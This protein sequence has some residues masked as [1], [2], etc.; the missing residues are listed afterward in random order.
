MLKSL[1]VLRSFIL[2]L[3]SFLLVLA[4][5]LAKNIVSVAGVT[6]FKVTASVV[7]L[8]V[9]KSLLVLLDLLRLVS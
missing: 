2:G 8:L 5:L 9:L 7:Q 1:L 3:R 4:L 6:N